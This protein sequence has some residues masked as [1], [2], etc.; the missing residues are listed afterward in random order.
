M[1][2]RERVPVAERSDFG[3]LLD[4]LS[5]ALV[6]NPSGV[7]QVDDII[8]LDDVLAQLAAF[9]EVDHVVLTRPIH[10]GGAVRPAS[11][12]ARPG[13]QP[14]DAFDPEVDLPWVSA[15]L[16]GGASVCL[17]K[18]D[19][20]PAGAEIDRASLHRLGIRSFAS[21][22]L[23]VDGA[24]MGSFMLGTVREDGSWPPLAVAELGRVSELLGRAPARGQAA[25]ELRHAI[26]FDQ[27][28]AG[29]AANLIR[30]PVDQIDA[31]IV[32]TLRVV[33]TLL[34]ADR[35]IVLQSDP[36]HE[37]LRRTHLWVRPGT[38]GP[39][40]FDPH[41]AF[42]WLTARLLKDGELVALTRLD[43]LPPEAARD[44]ATLERNGVISGA[45]TPM[46]VEHR[47]FGMLAFATVTQAQR[48]SP[49][50]VARLRLVGEIIASALGRRDAEVALRAALAEN[51]H[52][53]ER[54][55]AE[56]LYLHAELV[57][58]R[59][60]GEIVGQSAALRAA[61]EKV[62]QVAD[63]TAPVLLLGETGTGKELLGRALHA[64]SRRRARS[65]IA[66][67]CAA[68][69]AALIES[70][71]FGH[72][73]GAFTGAS[74]AK[75]G[76]FELA[77][78]GTLLLDEIGELEPA[79]QAKL[80]RVIEDGEIQRLGSTAT[81]KV[82]V[83]LI[84]ATNRDLR[85]EMREGRF[86]SDLYYRL[87]VFPI[88]LPP[89]RDRREDIPLLVWHF[90]QSRQRALGRTIRKIPKAAM[91]T[92]QTYE[93]PGNV[94]ELQ[95]VV[96][97]AMI[98][99]DGPILHVEEAFGATLSDRGVEKGRGVTESLRDIERGH[100][101]QVLERCEWTIEG[102]GQ[103]AERLGLNPSTLRN[104]MRKLGIRRP[105]R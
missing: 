97:R 81:R 94:R 2:G 74:Q 1:A 98:L 99:S 104:R 39:P 69:P 75:P 42:P 57:E 71:L 21:V 100:I 56:N 72:E 48:W 34:G 30:A 28:V 76:R 59:D 15:R 47:A 29:R 101:V 27:A 63:T 52:L 16:A 79:L 55:T 35:G 43:E 19:D 12:W 95:N 89:L 8:Q 33:G 25:V 83:R 70:E 58:A 92:L 64:H 13:C 88:E 14:L 36:T 102:R 65:F 80:L 50:L 32:E 61:L 73:K 10:G 78:Q 26:E 77:D 103:A 4:R 96:E 91:A 85:R 82:E 41:S 87:S 7:I 44:R 49:D 18:L 90:I 53:R 67:N 5:A 93:W 68:L 11:Q 54:L 24:P 51:E 9:F 62:R 22:P 20:L 3:G 45:L 86:R 40:P 17:A 60:F 84:A 38:S 46:V 6:K 105:A 31:Q 37:V 66:V 23:I